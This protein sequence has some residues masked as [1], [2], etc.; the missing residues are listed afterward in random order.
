M[1]LQAGIAGQVLNRLAVLG[2]AQLGS[3]TQQLLVERDRALEVGDLDPAV[4]ETGD[5]ARPRSSRPAPRAG[6][7]VP[8]AGG[9]HTVSPCAARGKAARSPSHGSAKNWSMSLSTSSIDF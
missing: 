8:G 2:P 6:T 3:N 7:V 4:V 1:N 5:L 9:R